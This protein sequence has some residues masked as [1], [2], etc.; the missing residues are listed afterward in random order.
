MP[1]ANE[2]RAVTGYERGAIT[3]FGSRQPL[4]VIVDQAGTE[5]DVVAIG[6]GAHGGNV[7]RAPADLIAATHAA[8]ADLSAP[9]VHQHE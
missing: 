8:V 9:E 3:P 4:P 6:G 2:A 7:H 5:P 1:D